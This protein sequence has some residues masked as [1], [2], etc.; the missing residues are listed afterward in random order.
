MIKMVVFAT[1]EN[2]PLIFAHFCEYKTKDNLFVK[3]PNFRNNFIK[4]FP[5]NAR[6]YRIY[7]CISGGFLE[8]P[9]SNK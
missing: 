9:L 5:R 3:I 7:S 8:K 1:C 2:Q 6:P 4:E